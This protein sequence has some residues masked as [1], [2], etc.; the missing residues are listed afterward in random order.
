VRAPERAA[1]IVSMLQVRFACPHCGRRCYASRKAA[2]RAARLLYPG[3]H[4][5]KYSCG[6]YW[7]VSPMR[8]KPAPH[9]R[10]RP[11]R[12]QD[13]LALPAAA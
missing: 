11:A 3:T 2:R 10:R 8:E 4:M 1:Q 13:R 5:R 12:Q 7:H 6:S 9:C